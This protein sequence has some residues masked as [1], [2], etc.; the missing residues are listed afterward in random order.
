MAHKNHLVIKIGGTCCPCGWRNN[1]HKH[2][3]PQQ[4]ICEE[5][6]HDAGQLTDICSGAYNTYTRWKMYVKLEHIPTSKKNPH[7]NKTPEYV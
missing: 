7:K 6:C 1:K 5:M 4:I 2:K 3:A